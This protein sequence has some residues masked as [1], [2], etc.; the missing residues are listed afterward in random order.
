MRASLLCL[1]LLVGCV[2]TLSDVA[3]DAARPDDAIM[4]RALAAWSAHPDLPDIGQRC[5][6]ELPS[7]RV[8]VVDDATMR[9]RC[10]RRVRGCYR[11]E[12]S[13][14][15][16]ASMFSDLGGG[17]WQH[18]IYIRAGESEA[19]RTRLTTHELLHWL[20]ACTGLGGDPSHL[21]PAIWTDVYG[22]AS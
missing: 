4:Q 9:A 15:W 13:C 7:L 8:A 18:A 3:P 14:G 17:C 20:A 2:T 10:M 21:R 12:R 16:P 22:A 6:D 19:I 5:R 1:A 11:R